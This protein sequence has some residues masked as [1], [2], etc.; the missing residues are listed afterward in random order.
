MY[1]KVNHLERRNKDGNDERV[2]NFTEVKIARNF[3]SREKV[4]K[5]TPDTVITPLA[6]EQAHISIVDIEEGRKQYSSSED[7][8]QRIL[9]GQ[10]AFVDSLEN[11]LECPECHRKAAP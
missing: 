9:T 8:Q 1:K 3:N 11:Y 2:S 7:V 10:I 5:T 4:L 6:L